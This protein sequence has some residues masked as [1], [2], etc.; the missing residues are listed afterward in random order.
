[1]VGPVSGGWSCLGGSF[2]LLD[3]GWCRC[4][5]GVCSGG[6]CG[7]QCWPV[8]GPLVPVCSSW[9]SLACSLCWAGSGGWSGIPGSTSGWVTGLT[10]CR[11]CGRHYATLAVHPICRVARVLPGH[12]VLHGVLLNVSTHGRAGRNGQAVV[13]MLS[14]SLCCSFMP[15]LM[16]WGGGGVTIPSCFLGGGAWGSCSATCPSSA[17]CTGSLGVLG[18]WWC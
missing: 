11:Q 13:L 2:V 5:R 10:S 9:N 6:C 18:R 3:E 7:G 12:Q 15:L 8:V 14:S 4:I 1:M 17:E 16:V